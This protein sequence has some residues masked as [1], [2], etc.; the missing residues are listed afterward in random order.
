MQD[1]ADTPLAQ[2]LDA[3]GTSEAHR[4]LGC[5][6]RPD[7]AQEKH[8][9]LFVLLLFPFSL[10]SRSL[11]IFPFLKE[12]L[13]THFLKPKLSVRSPPPQRFLGLCWPLF[14]LLSILPVPISCFPLVPPPSPSA[15]APCPPLP[16][17]QARRYK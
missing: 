14:S 15:G 3:A 1:H 5:I 9:T 7:G 6:I 4:G 17:S 16:P 13:L 12:H 11:F 8:P 2:P 10:F